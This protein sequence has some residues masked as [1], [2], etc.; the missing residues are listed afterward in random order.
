MR[1]HET[2]VG[3]VHV[4]AGAFVCGCVAPEPM[5]IADVA[6]ADLPTVAA[7]IERAVE[8]SVDA[9]AEEKAAYRTNIAGNLAWWRDHRAEAVHLK[10]S[11][12]GVLAGVVLVKEHWNLCHLFVDP[13]A[14]RRGIGTALVREAIARCRG[15]S[16]RGRLR[17][18]AARNAVPFYERLGFTRVPDAPAPFADVQFEYLL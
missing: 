14:Q 2:V 12:A 15:R 16:A 9:T 4:A 11:A 1:T 3:G 10:F 18:N 6:I 8:R 5:M 13:A 17:L 7:L